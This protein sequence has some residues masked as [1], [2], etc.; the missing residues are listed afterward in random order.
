MADKV[1]FSTEKWPN[2][3]LTLASH[4]G[5]SS[6]SRPAAGVLISHASCMPTHQWLLLPLPLYAPELLLL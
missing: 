6:R 1:E 2:L 3:S 4:A 5:L